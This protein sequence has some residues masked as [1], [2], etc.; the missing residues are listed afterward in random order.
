MINDPFV[1]AGTTSVQTDSTCLPAGSMVITTSAPFTAATELSAISAP[2]AL[3]C[4]R[5]ASTRSNAVT[6]WPPLTRL[7]AIGPPILPKPMNA[8]LAMSI[9]SAARFYVA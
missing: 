6:V 2:S 1:M 3:A 7:A 8:M 4:A 9:S 5:E